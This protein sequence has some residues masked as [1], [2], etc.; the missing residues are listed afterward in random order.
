M[1]NCFTGR[2]DRSLYKLPAGPVTE[3]TFARCRLVHTSCLDRM[4]S[5]CLFHLARGVD[6]RVFVKCGY[7]KTTHELLYIFHFHLNI[8]YSRSLWR[9][10][11]KEEGLVATQWHFLTLIQSA[12]DAVIKV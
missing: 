3:C 12:Q 2:R 9:P 7:L 4:T 11:V 6:R 8:W 10:L 5:S 1:D